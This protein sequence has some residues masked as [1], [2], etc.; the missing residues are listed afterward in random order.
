M[1]GQPPVLWSR[2]VLRALERA[3]FREVNRVGSHL[4]LRRDGHIAIV[5]DHGGKDMPQGTL[6]GILKQAGIT[7]EEFQASP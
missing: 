4:K 6:R 5:P 3:G 1:A 7:I 2:P